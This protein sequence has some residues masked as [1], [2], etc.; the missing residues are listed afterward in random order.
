MLS[1][2]YFF[3]P[4]KSPVLKII[5]EKE[6]GEIKTASRWTSRTQEFVL[7]SGQNFQWSYER[8]RGFGVDDK[9]GT[10]LVLS[11][12]E[13]RLAALIRNKE[14]RTLG[15][16]SC[17]AGNGGKLILDEGV[18]QESVVSEELV[19]ATCLLMLKKELDRRR[20]VQFMMISTA[21]TA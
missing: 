10:A 3:G 20:V 4:G 13:K 21:V 15:S 18:G 6:A 2:T 16:K 7:P 14:T 11:V 9:K 17:S 12:G 1:T 19:V 8:E 5:G